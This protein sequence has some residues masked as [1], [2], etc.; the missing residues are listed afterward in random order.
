MIFILISAGF[1]EVLKNRNL[2]ILK[3]LLSLCILFNFSLC[4]YYN[5]DAIKFGIGSMNKDEYLMKHEREYPMAKFVNENLPADSIIIMAQEHRG[6]YFNRKTIDYW[7]LEKVSDEGILDYVAGLRKKGIPVY[8]L[9]V[10]DNQDNDIALLLK[11]RK[12]VYSIS[13]D[14][15][16]GIIEEYRLYKL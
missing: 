8:L 12:P 9:T 6:F 13:R 16:E 3:A 15:K 2:Y 14:V 7:I 10:S 11:R 1:Y 5:R 4:F